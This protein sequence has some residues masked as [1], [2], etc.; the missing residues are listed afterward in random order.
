MELDVFFKPNASGPW[1]HGHWGDPSSVGHLR[2]PYFRGVIISTMNFYRRAAAAGACGFAMSRVCG[3]RQARKEEKESL[4]EASR[5]A[6]EAGMELEL[7]G[8]CG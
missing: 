2:G 3:A 6:K 8:S 4:A 1:I 5:L 7:D